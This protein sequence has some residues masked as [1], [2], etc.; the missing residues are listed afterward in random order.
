M[1][2]PR[3]AGLKSAQDPSGT[4]ALVPQR[5]RPNANTEGAN[6]NVVRTPAAFELEWPSMHSVIQRKDMWE[7]ALLECNVQACL[8][9]SAGHL[10][11]HPAG[12]YTLIPTFGGAAREQG[13][14]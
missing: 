8:R 3:S 7:N 1:E 10:S 4:K 9:C 13:G 12:S 6:A 14:V 5:A 2:R 11:S